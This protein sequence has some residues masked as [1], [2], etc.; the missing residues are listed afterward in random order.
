MTLKSAL[1]KTFYAKARRLT[2]TMPW[3]NP[4][5]LCTRTLTWPLD[6]SILH[7]NDT[8][9]M[10]DRSDYTYKFLTCFYKRVDLPQV[11]HVPLSS[12]HKD[13]C[14]R[15]RLH[16]NTVY[17]YSNMSRSATYFYRTIALVSNVPLSTNTLEHTL[18]RTAQWRAC[19]A[20][21]AAGWWH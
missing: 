17:H 18:Q 5:K 19:H 8:V 11:S 10:T 7:Q 13:F 9:Y 6:L 2:E 1:F 21:W 3:E 16:H 12:T 4:W 20:T 14:L 15:P